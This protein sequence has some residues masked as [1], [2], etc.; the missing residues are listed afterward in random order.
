MPDLDSS[1]TI[2]IEQAAVEDAADILAL[3]K[4]AFAG[5]A[6]IYGDPDI[7]PLTQTLDSLITDFSRYMFLKASLDGQIIGSVRAEEQNGTCFIGRLIVNPE[8]QNRGIG[9]QLM[10]AIEAAF[11]DADRRELFTGHLSERNLYFYRK[12][13]YVEF[14]REQIHPGLTHVFMEK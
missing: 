1:D 6:A 8:C 9:K 4:L 7:P 5:E 12:L 13:G 11:P 10:A 14:K 3:Q 2:V